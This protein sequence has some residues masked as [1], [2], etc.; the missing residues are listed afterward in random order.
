MQADQLEELPGQ[1]STHGC[2]TAYSQKHSWA[3]LEAGSCSVI[4]SV[5]EG[6]VMSSHTIMSEHTTHTDTRLR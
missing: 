4:E 5:C 3:F 2:T 1:N 6:P